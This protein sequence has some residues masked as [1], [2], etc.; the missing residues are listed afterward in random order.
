MSTLIPI[1]PIGEFRKLK[2]TEMKR[3]NSAEIYSDGEYLFTFVNPQTDYIRLHVENLSQLP[4]DSIC[5]SA[6]LTDMTSLMRIS[7]ADAK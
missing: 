7:C 6:I 2:V 5:Q 1:I 4:I 3:L